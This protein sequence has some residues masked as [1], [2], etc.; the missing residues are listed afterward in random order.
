MKSKFIK[1]MLFCIITIT[2]LL[3]ITEIIHFFIDSPRKI[4]G[5]GLLVGALYSAIAMKTIDSFLW[6]N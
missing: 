6:K 5:L 3:C 4:L 1:Y 2:V